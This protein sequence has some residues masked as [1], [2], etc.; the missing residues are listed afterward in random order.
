MPELEN[1]TLKFVPLE[2]SIGGI[3]CKLV[4][5]LN[6]LLKFVFLAKFNFGIDVNKVHALNKLLASITFIVSNHGISIKR[7]HVLNMEPI[8]VKLRV[9]VK[10]GDTLSAI[11]L[12]NILRV[13]VHALKSIVDGNDSN[14]VLLLNAANQEVTFEV[15]PINL[16]CFKL[17]QFCHVPE[18]LVLLLT[19]RGGW[20]FKE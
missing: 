12:A 2:V 4:H 5:E 18:K 1:M 19:F 17:V 9:F 14:E 15:V 8:C 11:Q 13:S 10:I 6:I 3:D 20:V 16:T 7:L